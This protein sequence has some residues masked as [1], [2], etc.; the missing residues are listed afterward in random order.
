MIS[1]DNESLK[2][3]EESR[4]M[5]CILHPQWVTTKSKLQARWNMAGKG[6]SK[7]AREMYYIPHSQQITINSKQGSTL[8]FEATCPAG[9]VGEELHLPPSNLACPLFCDVFYMILYIT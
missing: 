4:G 9:Q 6:Y 3:S 7:E 8:T 2:Y 5:Y 1:G